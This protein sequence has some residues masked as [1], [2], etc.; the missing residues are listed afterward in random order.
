MR[1]NRSYFSQRLRRLTLLKYLY[2]WANYFCIA[3]PRTHFCLCAWTGDAPG[4]NVLIQETISYL[5]WT[6]HFIEDMHGM[7][8]R[9]VKHDRTKHVQSL[10]DELVDPHDAAKSHLWKHIHNVAPG[11]CKKGGPKPLPAL[12][13]ANGQLAEDNAQISSRWGDH[14]A[15]IEAGHKSSFS[16]LLDKSRSNF[17]LLLE[18]D[19]PLDVRFA[20]S[21]YELES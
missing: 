5:A 2:V 20:T 15:Q 19:V 18:H 1:K 13:L 12:K 10:A 17:A 14:F 8:T 6:R 9:L 7:V 21:R 11:L 4:V 3:G 16:E